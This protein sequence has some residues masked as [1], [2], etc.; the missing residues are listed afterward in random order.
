VNLNC[1][2]MGF[3]RFS[4]QAVIISLNCFNQ[5]TFVTVKW[6]V[7][8]SVRNEFLNI[9]LT[10]FGIKRAN[11]VFQL[12]CVKYTDSVTYMIFESLDSICDF[13]NYYVILTCT[14]Y[15]FMSVVGHKKPLYLFRILGN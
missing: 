12:S 9:N 13:F 7:F 10:S 2:F 4:V 15:I 6:C 14:K 5:M 11:K 1:V 8:F 3:V